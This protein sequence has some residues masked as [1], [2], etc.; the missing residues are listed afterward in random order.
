MV[1]YSVSRA[2]VTGAAQGI[3]REIAARLV[4]EGL[5]VAILDRDERAAQ[6]TA[7]AIAAT[8]DRAV[9]GLG[10]DVSDPD[11]MVEAVAAVAGEF[12]GLDTV[13]ANAGI[14]RDRMFHRLAR[15]D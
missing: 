9:L 13:V 2:I 7:A 5:N 3:G 11:A 14:T 6:E 1:T 15:E 8:S 4:S 10:V 12:G